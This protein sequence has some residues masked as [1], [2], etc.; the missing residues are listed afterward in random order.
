MLDKGTNTPA[1]LSGARVT[2]KKVFKDFHQIFLLFLLKP[3][4]EA[5]TDKLKEGL[6]S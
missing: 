3:K 1:Y 2:K 4:S 5:V 6:S